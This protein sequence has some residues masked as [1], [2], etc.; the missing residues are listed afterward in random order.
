MPIFCAAL[1][2]LSPIAE[3]FAV[4]EYFSN[5]HTACLIIFQA[6]REELLCELIRVLWSL[7][8]KRQNLRQALIVMCNYFGS[9]PSKIGKWL[10][11][12]W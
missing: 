12:T 1:L 4:R 5:S 6:M 9:T 7:I 2:K 8:E 10:A 11:M 3:V